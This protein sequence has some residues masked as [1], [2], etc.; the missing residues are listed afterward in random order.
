MV[1]FKEYLNEA[2]EIA[3]L[4]AN[5]SIPL[6]PGLMRRLGYFESDVK[7]YHLTNSIH[8]PEMKKNQKKRNA[9][10][11]CFTKGGP[12]LAR[13]PS[14]PNVL[15]LL[16]GDSLIKGE[17]DIWTIRSVRGRRWLDIRNRKLTTGDAKKLTK[18][19]SGVLQ[20]TADVYGI[21]IDA[22]KSSPDEIFKI[23]QSQGSLMMYKTY[24][25]KLESMLNKEYKLLNEYLRTAAEM[26]YNEVILDNWKMLEIYSVD[27][28]SPATLDIIN[29]LNVPYKG[30]I[31]QKEISKLEI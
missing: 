27:F 17:T 23:I 9:Q 1:N 5:K 6:E 15:L 16:Q 3:Q 14:Q 7:A 4:I 12:E 26:K 30:I 31:T 29:K 22:Y 18:Y 28:E 8:L 13:I 24:L 19:M 25:T 11:S 20:S 21:D 10:L 2:T